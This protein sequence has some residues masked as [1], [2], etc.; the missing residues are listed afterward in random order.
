MLRDLT[1]F[2]GSV[3]KTEGLGDFKLSPLLKSKLKG[4]LNSQGYDFNDYTSYAITDK[5]TEDKLSL[6]HI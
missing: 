3:V 4:L 6:I 2:K 5:E 1:S